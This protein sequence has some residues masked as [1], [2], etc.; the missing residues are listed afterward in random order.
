[1]DSVE[2]QDL[3]PCASCFEPTGAV[4]ATTAPR[5]FVICGKDNCA[6]WAYA[7]G[8]RIFTSSAT[9]LAARPVAPHRRKRAVCD[10]CH[11]WLP[12]AKRHQ[13]I[14]GAKR[15]CTLSCLEAARP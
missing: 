1:M 6:G 12:T 7:L 14:V 4:W 8:E 2:N 5:G 9:V 10:Q 13:F 3:I 11:Q 15:Y